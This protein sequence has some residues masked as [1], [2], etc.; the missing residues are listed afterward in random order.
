MGLAL[1]N[2]LQSLRK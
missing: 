2:M 1:I